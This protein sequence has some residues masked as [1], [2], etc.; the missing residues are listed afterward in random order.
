MRLIFSGGASWAW[1][2]TPWGPQIQT[3][4]FTVAI[5]TRPG[6]HI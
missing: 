6:D 4:F 1:F 2:N 3:P 5:V